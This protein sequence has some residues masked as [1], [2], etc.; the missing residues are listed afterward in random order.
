[1]SARPQRERERCCSTD[2]LA[3]PFWH[4]V[5]SMV[6]TIRADKATLIRQRIR[7]REGD[8]LSPLAPKQRQFRRHRAAPSIRCTDREDEFPL[9]EER[10]ISGEERIARVVNARG[11]GRRAVE[12]DDLKTAAG[13]QF[14]LGRIAN[15]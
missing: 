7:S 11:F 2:L 15:V 3:E 5:F 4:I 1:M 12:L 10:P 9:P 8:G 13:P 14:V 6:S